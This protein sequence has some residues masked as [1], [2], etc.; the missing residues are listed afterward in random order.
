MTDL[1]KELRK[2]WTD[3][4]HS[5]DLMQKAADKIERLREAL[6]KISE[7][8]GCGSS[9]ITCHDCYDNSA[10]AKSTLKDGQ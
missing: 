2:P 7:S 8:D 5:Q 6:E 3:N 1:V 9:F 10:L 4:Q